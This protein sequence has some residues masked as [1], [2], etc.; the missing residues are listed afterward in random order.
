M[1]RLTVRADEPR[2]VDAEEHGQVLQAHVVQHLVERALEE[3]GVQADDGAHAA[4][5]HAR[6]HRDGVL[7]ADADVEKA[8]GELC[9]KVRKSHAVRHGGGDADELFVLFRLPA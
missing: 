3:G 1:M 6:S 2:A 8:G 4:L 5:R 7:L 9:R